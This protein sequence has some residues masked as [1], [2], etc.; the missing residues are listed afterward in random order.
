MSYVDYMGARG[1][2]AQ[3]EREAPP[4]DA[5]KLGAGLG[6]ARD[7]LYNTGCIDNKVEPYLVKGS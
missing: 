3:S 6:N 5:P 2:L 7:P 1:P 4:G